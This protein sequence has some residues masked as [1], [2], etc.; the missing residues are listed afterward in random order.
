MKMKT[1]GLFLGT[2]IIII[3]IVAVLSTHLMHGSI[4]YCVCLWVCLF[5]Y[6]HM[7]C[8]IQW[9]SVANLTFRRYLGALFLSCFWFPS[10]L[11]LP[12]EKQHAL[13]KAFSVELLALYFEGIM[14]PNLLIWRF[15]CK[16]F[17]LEPLLISY[18]F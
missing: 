1:G 5:S 2:L 6:H 16:I 15:S 17:I 7:I 12:K 4:Q 14:D 8:F 9:C 10:Q 11:H 18:L 13:F 3:M